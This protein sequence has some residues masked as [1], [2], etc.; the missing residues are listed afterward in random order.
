[1]E[2]AACG[3]I[4]T[5]GYFTDEACGIL[6]SKTNAIQQLG[7][8]YEKYRLVASRMI[9]RVLPYARNGVW[10]DI[11]IGNGALLFTAQ[12]YGF[13]PIGTDLRADNIS[14]L[15]SFGIEAHATDITELQLSSECSVISMADVLEHMAF[16]KLGLAAANRLLRDEGVLLISMPNKDSMLWKML[17]GSGANPYWGEIEHY[18]NFGRARLFSLLKE[19]GFEPRRYGTSERYR[20]CMEI[21]AQKVRAI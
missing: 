20:A 11:G 4:F 7:A 2:C 13:E 15:S 19:F 17:N 12:E 14:I 8:D 21:V 5:E 6:F 10:L 16:P 1:M 3:H 18:H 9:D